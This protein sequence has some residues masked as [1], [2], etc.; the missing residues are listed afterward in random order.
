VLGC[1]CAGA[2]APTIDR[3]ATSVQ[4]Q[5]ISIQGVPPADVQRLL[6]LPLAVRR[7]DGEIVSPRDDEP[8]E[9]VAI[10]E[11]AGPG[12]GQRIRL[13]VVDLAVEAISGFYARP[14]DLR[15]GTRVDVRDADL[16]RLIDGPLPRVLV[17][18]VRLPGG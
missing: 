11:L 9:S 12:E 10:R 7:V 6:E 5:R 15:T 3:A 14:A 2:A 16:Q 17:L 4:V 1:A 13:S 8:A 18:R